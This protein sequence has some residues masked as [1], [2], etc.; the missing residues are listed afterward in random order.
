MEKEIPVRIIEEDILVAPC[1]PDGV[2]NTLD[3]ETKDGMC[4]CEHFRCLIDRNNRVIQKTPLSKGEPQ[5][6]K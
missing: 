6:A 2:A 5:L 1:M 3:E 4:V